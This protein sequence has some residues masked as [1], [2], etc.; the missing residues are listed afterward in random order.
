[1]APELEKAVNKISEDCT[2]H[3]YVQ[4]WNTLSRI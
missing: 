3:H 2:D 4:D 1:M